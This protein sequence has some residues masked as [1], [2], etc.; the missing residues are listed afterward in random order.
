MA[1]AD[2]MDRGNTIPVNGLNVRTLVCNPRPLIRFSEH[3]AATC[4]YSH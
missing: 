4:V 2:R 3:S 1:T